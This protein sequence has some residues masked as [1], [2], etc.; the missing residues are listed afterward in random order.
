MISEALYVTDSPLFL[1]E[2]LCNIFFIFCKVNKYFQYKTLA[3]AVT[4]VELEQ[5]F[6]LKWSCSIVYKVL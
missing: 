5:Y 3:T 4:L 1:A 2:T 6:T